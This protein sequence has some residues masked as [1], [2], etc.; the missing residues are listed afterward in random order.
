[1]YSMR[2]QNYSI[3]IFL[4]NPKSSAKNTELEYFRKAKQNKKIMS[5]FLL[6]CIHFCIE[7]ALDKKF[8]HQNI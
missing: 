1:M 8:Y 2:S 5:C 6:S 7:N 4:H 3:F